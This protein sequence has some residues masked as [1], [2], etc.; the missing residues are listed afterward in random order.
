MGTLHFM[1]PNLHPCCDPVIPASI[2]HISVEKK[3]LG[4]PGH[5]PLGS[6]SSLLP[7]QGLLSFLL[8]LFLDVQVPV[9]TSVVSIKHTQV[10]LHL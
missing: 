4:F 6:G 5:T 3:P 9:S 2:L 1:L 7:V 10:S 8:F